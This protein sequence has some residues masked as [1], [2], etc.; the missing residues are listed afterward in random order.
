[1]FAFVAVLPAVPIT[2]KVFVCEKQMLDVRRIND[3]NIFFIL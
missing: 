2:C 3:V 1:V